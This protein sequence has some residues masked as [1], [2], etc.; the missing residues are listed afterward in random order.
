MIIAI[1]P[2]KGGSKRL[3]NKNMILLNSKPM[4]QY[5]IEYVRSCSLIDE[6]YVST[7]SDSINDFVKQLGVKV[8]RRPNTL[9]GETPIID[10]YKHA[11]NNVKNKELVK[12]L[13]GVQ[14]DHPDRNISLIKAIKLFK[15]KNLDRLLSKDIEGN[16]N[17][18]HYI[19]SRSFLDT[20][21]S[22]KDYITIDNCTNV[23]YESDL[24]NASKRLNRL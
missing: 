7:D 18:A 15:N 8:I 17:G 10:V 22:K 2:A 5:A 16:K 23:H 13:V 1:I 6:L 11:L 14:P 20:G 12:V 19:L 24:A 21:I 9:G 3:P 4:I